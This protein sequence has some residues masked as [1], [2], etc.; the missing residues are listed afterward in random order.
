[1]R[2]EIPFF[3]PDLFAD[4]RKVMLELLQ[5][6]GTARE[7]KFILGTRT[8]DFE[9]LLRDSLGA[10]DVVACGSGTA[11][12]G[13]VLRA[14]GI[15]SGDEVVVPA[16][17]CAPLASSVLEVGAKPVF[18][19]IDPHTMVVDPDDVERRITDRAKAIMPAH[20]FSI[21]A[22][23]PRLVELA[24][25]HKLRLLEDSAV[26]Q[27]AVLRGTPA[28][29]WGN[30][31]VFSFV[32]VKSFG[33]PGEGG[34]VV[35]GDPELGR[36][37]RMLRNHGQN[38]R[39]FVYDIVG[40]NSRFDEIQAAF[41]T[42]RFAGFPARLERRAAIADYYT[43]RFSRLNG[44]AI[45]PPPPGR[46]GRCYYVY[47]LQV[48]KRDELRDHLASRGIGSHVYYPQ[49]LPLQAGFAPHAPAGGRWPNAEYAS[50]RILALPIYP[51]LSDS[52]VARIADAVCDFAR[53]DGALR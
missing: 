25:Q 18:A 12:L 31:G 27:G 47:C 14:M 4:D 15:G 3:P 48:E 29:L 2:A 41:Q 49:P 24:A 50:R 19:D 20:M 16:F 34:A 7:Q 9:E 5:E 8:A 6:I 53:E 45:V 46:E 43:E 52:E 36:T 37:V 28:G 26:A 30:A 35:T 40:T 13:L 10:A 51:H 1:M 11:A 17:G 23:M 39:R 22:D 21:M 33:M 38:R 44:R 42:Y 32:Q